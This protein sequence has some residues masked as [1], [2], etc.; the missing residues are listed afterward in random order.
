[1]PNLFKRWDGSAWITI[2][3]DTR[4]VAVLSLTTN[5]GAYGAP[6]DTPKVNLVGGRA[7]L[8]GS[9]KNNTGSAFT[10]GTIATVPSGFRPLFTQT[11]IALCS[12][13]AGTCR[14]DVSAAGAVTLNAAP[15]VSIANLG[16]ISFSGLNWSIS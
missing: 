13:A 12:A 3:D 2:F 6:Y 14:L 5:W 9:I 1:M 15:A 7:Y 16:W 8:A 4:A 11:L 10:T